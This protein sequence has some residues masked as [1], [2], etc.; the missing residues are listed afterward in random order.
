MSTITYRALDSNNDP[1]WGQGLSNLLSD[2][3]AVG[4][5]IL[6]RLRLFEGEWW[7]DQLDGLPLWQSILGVTANVKHIT[8]LIQQRILS[9]PYVTGISQVNA[10]YTSSSRLYSFSA[11][12]T[13]QFGTQVTI[14]YP[15]PPNQ[16]LPS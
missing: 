15:T 7:A 13:T 14:T 10:V 1:I 11:V 16:G 3:D 12:V 6:T 2:T 5:L 8:L 4:Q 9:T